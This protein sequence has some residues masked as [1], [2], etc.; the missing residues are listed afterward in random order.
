MP[1]FEIQHAAPLSGAQKDELA[2]A[3]T[4]L[5]CSKFGTPSVF[6]TVIFADGTKLDTY[7]AGKPVSFNPKLGS[8]YPYQP[9]HTLL[10]ILLLEF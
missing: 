9:H 7:I 10:I 4:K 5:Q 8:D 1:L 3:I 6:V 2:L